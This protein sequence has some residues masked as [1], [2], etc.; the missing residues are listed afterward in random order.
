M[1]TGLSNW[2]LRSPP[3]PREDEAPSGWLLRTAHAHQ[4][5]SG[6]FEAIYGVSLVECDLG[7]G[8]EI[9]RDL[10]ARLRLR[11]W[12]QPSYVALGLARAALLP[13][14]RVRLTVEDWWSYCPRCW[15]ED[16]RQA[17]ASYVRKAWC[18]PF[19]LV[20]ESHS[21]RLRAWPRGLESKQADSSVLMSPFN[22]DSLREAAASPLEAQLNS[23]LARPGVGEWD[24]YACVVSDLADALLS[25]TG[26]QGQG[27]PAAFEFAAG[28]TLPR[29]AGTTR[30]PLHDLPACGA[31]LRIALLS[32]VAEL[33]WFDVADVRERPKWLARLVKGNARSPAPR[34]IDPACSDPLF[35]LMAS[36]NPLAAN[37]LYVRSESWPLTF[38][39]RMS[40]AALI[41]ALANTS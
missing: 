6:E 28:H 16:L 22:G 3:D 29:F 4:L 20:C 34:R 39:R 7:R 13:E 1:E 36:L 27:S 2:G 32:I 10:A 15:A 5:S 24:G 38:R 17:G 8:D 26:P 14:H 30:L 25:R 21:V 41:G 11:H 18:H 19:A 12:P 33:V 37:A 31:H 9:L 40:A 35:L 23:V